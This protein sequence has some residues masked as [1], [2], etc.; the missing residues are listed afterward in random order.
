MSEVGKKRR[1]IR[2]SLRLA[3]QLGVLLI[4]LGT[5]GAV[6]FIEYSAQPSFCN[7]CHIMTPYYD[8]WATSTH[9]DV[10]CIKCHY[11]PGIK[12]EAM[13]K[14]QAANQVVKYV[15]GAYGTKP[16]AEIEDAAC[17]RSG[18]HSLR[19][20]EGTVSFVGPT[21]PDIVVRFDHTQHLGEL[22]RGKQLRCTSCHSQIVQGN[23]LAVETVTCNLCHFKERESDPVAGCV[24]CHRSV[25]R[26]VSPAGF[27]VDHQQYVR[28]L[29]SCTS[30]HD[31]VTSGTGDAEQARCFNCHNEPERIAEFE[32]TPLVHRVHITEHNVECTQCHT[33]IQHRLVSL[34]VGE[35]LECAS[36]HQRVHEAQQ[37]LYAGIGGH[38]AENLPSSMF[39]A[40]VS[41]TGCHELGQ[42]T[43][44]HE[45]V[46]FAGEA[47]CLSCHGIEYANILP[48]WQQEM[49]RKVREVERIVRGAASAA[50]SAP[51]RARATVDSLLALAQ[52]NLEFVQGGRGAH[53]IAY[54]DRLLRANLEFVRE[55]VEVGNLPYRVPAVDLGPAIGENVCLQ[56]H[57]GAERQESI[58]LDRPFDHERHAVSAGIECAACHTSLEDHGKTTLASRSDCAD[59]HHR[60][61]DELNCAT[62]HEGPGGAPEAP[63]EHSVGQFP[64]TPHRELGLQCATCHDPP[65]MA[66]TVDCAQC[67]GMHHQPDASCLSCHRE[68]PKAI[69]DV[70]FAHLA[71]SQCHGE[72]VEG[73]TEW[74]RN[75]CTVCHQDMVEHNAPNACHLC[76]DFP[77]PGAAEGG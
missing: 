13:G 52:A 16:W 48:S 5:I 39:L 61:I 40:R 71:C 37:Q 63:V 42:D 23:H 31:Q 18:C 44:G 68:S 11:A 41:C 34:N 77:A 64:H 36:C 27:V 22:R 65:S 33:P 6:G 72:Q 69:H 21:N 15:T 26:I 9:G 54:A 47:S 32:N 24:G 74:S 10:P 46:Q 58:F 4:I 43:R 14:F 1:A 75:V 29:V 19:K 25:P 17:L 20:V 67:H 66:A 60:Q 55:A 12:A 59:C 35:Q 28:D 2:I 30:C 50:G 8:S 3:V 73:I 38:G 51:V 56:C 62:C 70:S 45:R 49:N 7:K 76:H 53:N 57:L